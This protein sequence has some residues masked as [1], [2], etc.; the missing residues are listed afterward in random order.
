M[1]VTFIL[2]NMIQLKHFSLPYLYLPWQTCFANYSWT[3]PAVQGKEK[4]KTGLDSY[5]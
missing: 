1:L 2:P 3:F 5:Q 4:V